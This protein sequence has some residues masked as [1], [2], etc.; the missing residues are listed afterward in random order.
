MICTGTTTLPDMSMTSVS[1]SFVCRSVDQSFH[2]NMARTVHST[3]HARLENLVS[4]FS[5]AGNKIRA[6]LHLSEFIFLRYAQ[7][8]AKNAVFSIAFCV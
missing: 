5:Y 6:I 4:T 2:I 7:N 1:S 3:V 8:I